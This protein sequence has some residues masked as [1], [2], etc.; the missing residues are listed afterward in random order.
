MKSYTTRL[1]FEAY[2]RREDESPKQV[3][4]LSHALSLEKALSG[5]VHC[6]PHVSCEM[7]HHTKDD[8]HDEL[9][10]CPCVKRWDEL[11]SSA[12]NLLYPTKK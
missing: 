3:V 2:E 6:R 10:E 1:S 7:F 9:S 11:N 4:E 8:L 12:L 5:L